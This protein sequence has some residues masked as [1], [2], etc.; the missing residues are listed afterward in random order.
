MRG[1]L[2]LAC[3]FLGIGLATAQDL[4]SIYRNGIVYLDNAEYDKANE[5]FKRAG[6]GYRK[7]NNKLGYAKSVLQT[8]K[9]DISNK[10]FSD[11]RV[12]LSNLLQF[13]KE[14]IPN[15]DSLRVEILNSQS[16]NEKHLGN[17]K[18]AL[19]INNKLLLNPGLRETFPEKIYHTRS[20]IE[21]D[22][23][24]YDDAINSAKA[25]LDGYIRRKDSLNEAAIYNIIG[26]GYY[27]KNELDSTL[28]YYDKSLNLKKL[29]DANIGQLTIS[30][31]NIGIVH[32]ALANYEEAIRYYK[33]AEKYDLQNGGEQ[34]GVLSDIYV[35]LVNSYFSLG[36]Y[37][38][39][40]LYAEKA[41]NL[42]ERLYGAH[43]TFTSFVYISYANLLELKGEREKAITYIKKALEIRQNT[44]GELHRWTFESYYD[45]GYNYLQLGD[46]L[47]ARENFL[48]SLSVAQKL[49]SKVATCY[50]QKGLAELYLRS[51]DHEKAESL[52]LD[53]KGISQAVYG[54]D[55]DLTYDINNSLA[56]NYYLKGDIKNS[57]KL[58]SQFL[59]S[60][61]KGDLS[62]IEF[63]IP[64]ILDLKNEILL[65][66]VQETG[67]SQAIEE[68]YNNVLLQIQVI[69]RIRNRYSSSEAKI[70]IS[71]ELD[72]VIESALGKCY[73]LY[74]LTSEKR[75]AELAFKVSE[76]NRNHTLLEGIKNTYFKKIAGLPQDILDKENALKRKLVQLGKKI[77]YLDQSD[78]TDREEYN[79]LL[80]EQLNLNKELE[81][82]LQD[83]ERQYPKYYSLKYASEPLDIS[84]LQQ[85]LLT[86][87]QTLIEYYIGSKSGYVFYIDREGFRMVPIDD[88]QRVER[89]VNA[90]RQNIIEKTD[91]RKE[92]SYLYAALLDSGILKEQLIIVADGYLNYIPFETLLDNDTYLLEKH[93]ISYLASAQLL[94]TQKEYDVFN[95]NSRKWYGFSP[96]FSSG[97]DIAYAGDEV[98]SI[99][100]IMGGE[101]FK[102]AKATL[103]NFL[104]HAGDA[105]IL[106]VGTHAEMDHINPL[107]DKLLFTS[108]NGTEE[109]TASDIYT[110][111]INSDLVVLS[112]CN[113]GYGKIIEGEGVMH[114]ARAFHYA[115]AKSTVMSLWKVPDKETYEL[116]NLF[117][118]HLNNNLNK[119]EA[120]RQAKIDYLNRTDDALLKH[121]YFWAGFVVSGDMAALDQGGKTWIYLLAVL[122]FIVLVYRKKL[123]QFFK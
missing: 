72:D 22:L 65:E 57:E 107:Y 19:E 39:A 93:A 6:E 76:L 59:E 5:A 18:K 86:P 104:E 71:K 25:A 102:G 119:D 32:E 42:A 100:K 7:S 69:Q 64:E 38:N 97:E 113:T 26:V 101:H 88:I 30:T 45:L 60:Y 75:F 16:L 111:S 35:A 43:S 94:K 118:E 49:N 61:E 87:N 11:S 58:I 3:V 79:E 77:Y 40:E 117:Y 23:G 83:I 51:R 36:D 99:A 29:I 24:N 116:M 27:F 114:M 44:Y 62:V 14:H 46:T 13:Q 109:L 37:K 122:V 74:T 103:S 33:L 120:L 21:I 106:H 90:C 121:P 52:L 66:S 81:A 112:A 73:Q 2:I 15:E 98:A 1:L 17:F 92:A 50:S 68:L 105:S 80:S 78:D 20:R 96:V 63:F 53:A 70:Y 41:L 89:M 91:S 47:K 115:G 12:S 108:A 9:I 34:V 56:L 84:T 123:V 85:D 4:D 110:L 82:L 54:A 67:E 28:K 10:K 48:N 8:I 95:E 31:F 55:H